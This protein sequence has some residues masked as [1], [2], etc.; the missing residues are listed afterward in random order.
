ME[1]REQLEKREAGTVRV[2]VCG[3]RTFGVLPHASEYAPGSVAFVEDSARARGQRMLVFLTLQCLTEQRG[4]IHIIQGGAEG[5]DALAREWAQNNGAPFTTYTAEWR[6]HGKKA[7]PIRNQRMLD[8]ARPEVVVAFPGGSGTAD[9]VR[10][11][12]AASVEV[13]IAG[14]T[15]AQA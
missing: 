8:E 12:K 4:P 3:G 13:L 10:R 1:Q 14:A 9:M 6:R 5:A 7:G 15:P 2:L 11:A